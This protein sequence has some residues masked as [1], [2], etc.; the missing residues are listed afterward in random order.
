[1]MRRTQRRRRCVA[2]LVSHR[3]LK[4]FADTANQCACMLPLHKQRRMLVLRVLLEA[5]L[6]V[7]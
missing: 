7:E 4:L 5:C 3:A 1:M 2:G 6:L